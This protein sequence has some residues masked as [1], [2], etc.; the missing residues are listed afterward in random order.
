MSLLLSL[1]WVH[2]VVLLIKCSIV[3]FFK[4]YFDVRCF[5]S[6]KIWLKF[7]SL[8]ICFLHLF[9]KVHVQ[10]A[11]LF[12]IIKWS[13]MIAFESILN[14]YQ[15]FLSNWTLL[16]LKL[17][18]HWIVKLLNLM[19]VYISS[20]LLSP[21][22]AWCRLKSLCL[23]NEYFLH[24]L[25]RLFKTTSQASRTL[26]LVSFNSQEIDTL[27]LVWEFGH[28]LWTALTIESIVL[29]QSYF[30]MYFKIYS[31]SSL[32]L[33]YN[34]VYKAKLLLQNQEEKFWIRFHF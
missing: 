4:A 32:W 11:S 31:Y 13:L 8:E 10:V 21:L 5:Q 15:F 9:V 16:T 27:L 33:I 25:N 23:W 24:H 3:H 14:D 28:I 20:F 12:V 26:L 7:A 18:K 34:T 2:L 17:L 19:S 22:H 1:G 6:W 30:I 29:I